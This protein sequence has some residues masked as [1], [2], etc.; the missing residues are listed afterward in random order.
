MA[1]L[2]ARVDIYENLLNQLRGQIDSAG[3]LAISK[4]LQGVRLDMSAVKFGPL[5]FQARL[6]DFLH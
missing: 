3:Q 6:D 2:R 4:A 1:D 5:L